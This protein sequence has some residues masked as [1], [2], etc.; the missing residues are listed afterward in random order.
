[1]VDGKLQVGGR[2]K[3]AEKDQSNDDVQEPET[4]RSPL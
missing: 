1:M 4:G 2:Q 3:N